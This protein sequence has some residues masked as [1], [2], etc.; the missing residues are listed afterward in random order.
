MDLVNWCK[1]NVSTTQQTPGILSILMCEPDY[2]ISHVVTGAESSALI[3][4]K[5]H[6]GRNQVVVGDSIDIKCRIGD[7]TNIDKL[8]GP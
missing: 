2:I 8:S 5:C 6:E 4:G 1:T 7:Q 3:D